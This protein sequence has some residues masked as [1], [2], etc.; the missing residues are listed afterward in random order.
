MAG[1]DLLATLA[2]SVMLGAIGVALRKTLYR[3]AFHRRIFTLGLV[4]LLQKLLLG[5]VGASFSLPF[6]VCHTIDQG[7]LAAA[8][9]LLAFAGLTAL[10]WVPVAMLLAAAALVRY[11]D[12]AV[13]Y[14]FSIFPLVAGA[15]VIAW[16]AAAERV[17]RESLKA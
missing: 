2:A 10:F 16:N 11:G 13:P 8:F 6:R 17:H 1:R 15:T 12:A 4:I 14:T 3:N 9:T 5:F 7:T